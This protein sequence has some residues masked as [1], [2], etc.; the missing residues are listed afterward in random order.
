[1]KKSVKEFIGY[2]LSTKDMV[3]GKVLD[4][5]FDQERWIIRYME[6]DQGK[7]LP[8]KKVLIPRAMLEHPDKENENFHVGITRKELE[9]CPATAEK[10]PVSREYE[11]ELLNHLQM[12]NY[13]AGAPPVTEG[14]MYPLRPVSPPQVQINEDDID[15]HLRSFN[16]ILG[17]EIQTTN[18]KFGKLSDIIVDDEDWHIIYFIANEEM[19]DLSRELMVPIGWIKKISYKDQEIVLDISKESLLK[20]PEFNPASPI[21]IEYEKKVYDYY[22]RLQS[23][24]KSK[25]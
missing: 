18:G 8:N 19:N 16:E 17:Y 2:S 12:K 7:I 23:T 3:K 21:N 6:A 9:K 5:Y 10:K 22:G 20:A 4:F 14:M 11:T 25:K 24:D 15:S 1:M 13:W